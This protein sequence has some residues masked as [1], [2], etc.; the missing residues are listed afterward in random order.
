MTKSDLHVEVRGALIIVSQLDTQSYAIYTK[1]A[2]QPE[3]VLISSNATEDHE[4]RARIWQAAN[5]KARE[6]GWIV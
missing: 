3:L 1:P 5:D 6:L 4:L 2:G